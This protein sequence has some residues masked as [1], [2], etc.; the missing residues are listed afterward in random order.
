MAEDFGDGDFAGVDR[1]VDAEGDVIAE[2]VNGAAEEVEAG[3][4]V[5]YGGGGESLDGGEKRL[6]FGGCGG[7][8]SVAFEDGFISVMFRFGIEEESEIISGFEF[9]GR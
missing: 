9:N 2:A 4:E 5:G 8:R 1:G 6:G 3:T 7:E